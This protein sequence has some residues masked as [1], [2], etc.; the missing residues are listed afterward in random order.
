M[1]AEKK[2]KVAAESSY[3][4]WTGGEGDLCAGEKRGS[5]WYWRWEGNSA[6]DGDWHGPYRTLD[7]AKKAEAGWT[8]AGE[9]PVTE[10]PREPRYE[11]KPLTEWRLVDRANVLKDDC[12]HWEIGESYGIAQKG[13]WRVAR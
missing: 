8:L 7:G 4:T 6:P 12:L 2:G 9:G 3:T 11:I 13:K 5:E 10:A 1:A